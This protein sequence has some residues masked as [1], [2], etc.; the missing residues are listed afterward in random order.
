MDLV[1]LHEDLMEMLVGF[2]HL[3]MRKN[4]DLNSQEF[5]FFGIEWAKLVYN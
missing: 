5:G 4:C 3:K 1:G 2:Q